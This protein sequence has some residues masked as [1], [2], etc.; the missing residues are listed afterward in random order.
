MPRK[1]TQTVKDARKPVTNTPAPKPRTHRKKRDVCATQEH[2]SGGRAEVVS[3]P[4]RLLPYQRRWVE[5]RSPLKIVVKARQIGY[6]F[7]ATLQ[8]LL[9]CMERKTT[10]IFLSKGERQS[11]LLMEKVQEHI[12][13][14]GIVAQAFESTFFE[15]ASQKQLE[16]RFP[17]GSVIYGLPSNPDTARGYSGNVTLDEFAFHADA[18][19]I[20]AA[21]FPTI[22]RGYSLEVISTPNGQQGKF[23]E[24]AK[25]ADLVGESSGLSFSG[26]GKPQTSQTAR[27]LRHPSDLS[28]SGHWC[29]VYEAVRQ[30]LKINIELLRSGCD[31][32]STFQ[33]EFCCQFVSTTENFFPPELLAACLS[34]EAS[35]DTSPLLLA[36]ARGTERQEVGNRKW[37]VGQS[38]S[39]VRTS[40]F[41]L[42]TSD[43]FL[44]ID[45]GRQHDR[46]VFWL[47]EVNS[48]GGHPERSEGSALQNGRFLAALGMTSERSHQDM[49]DHLAIARMVRTLDRAPFAE[50]LAYARELMALRREDGSPLVRRAAIDSTGIGAMLAETLAE[51]F[52]PRL[53]PVTFTAAVKENLAFRTKRRMENRLSLLPDTRDVRRAFSAVKKYVTPSGNLR[54][55]AVRTAAGHADAFWAKA[56]AD[57]AADSEPASVAADGYLVGGSAIINPGAFREIAEGWGETL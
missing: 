30:G 23:Y 51:E 25:A 4:I 24:L 2:D 57:L 32:E 50:Q 8:A 40:Y 5:D 20:Y 55:D 44:G 52:G 26:I 38:L 16:V 14:C 34:A 18:A 15:G 56:L 43:F 42:P 11:K 46:T 35:A 31:D 49:H 29:D 7:S 41:P 53:E 27:R 45:I 39:S 10:W 47:D 22:T 9:R 17:N 37:E 28:W 13:S 21:L 3:T 6:S 19:K 1:K 36:S 33:Q 12:Q 48:T 54:F